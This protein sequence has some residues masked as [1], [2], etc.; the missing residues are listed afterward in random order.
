MQSR[1][2]RLILI[3]GTI[4]CVLLSFYF[5][6]LRDDLR[7]FPL[8][9]AYIHFVYAKNLA[10]GHGLSFNAGETSFGTSSPLWVFLLSRCVRA[11]FDLYSSAIMLSLCCYFIS[12]LMIYVTCREILTG[13][14]PLKTPASS[15]AQ[16]YSFAAALIYLLSG[17]MAWQAFSGMETTL[18]HAL[19]LM[20]LY[21][22]IKTGYGFTTALLSGVLLLCRINGLS[23]VLPLAAVDV[24]QGRRLSPF[25]ILTLLVPLPYY[26]YAKII[27]G[28]FFPVTAQGKL[29]TYVRADTHLVDI[30]SFLVSIIK[31]LFLY[32]PAF[33]LLIILCVL[34]PGAIALPLILSPQGRRNDYTNTSSPLIWRDWFKVRG[35]CRGHRG[36]GASLLFLWTL[37]DI[38][39]HCLFFPSLNNHLRYLSIIFLTLPLS[40][41]LLLFRMQEA[42]S[43]LKKMLAYLLLCLLPLMCLLRQPFWI[44]TY[45]NN[46]LHMKQVYSNCAEWI[47]NNTTAAPIA[48][49]DIGVLKHVTDR[50]VLDL[51][52]VTT[53]A[54]HPFLLQHNAGTYLREKG[55]QLIVYSRFPDC[56]VWSG[57]YRS[58]YDRSGLL[59]ETLLKSFSTDYYP[60]PSITHSFQ[61]DVVMID[62][63][64]PATPEGLKEKFYAGNDQWEHAVGKWVGEGL[65]L[66]GFSLEKDSLSVTWKMAQSLSIAY[67]WKCNEKL[68]NLPFIHTW[69]INAKTG[70]VIIHT[71]HIPT[72]NLLD[73]SMW[74]P[75]EVIKEHHVLW[76][77]DTAPAGTYEIWVSPADTLQMENREG[78][79][80][81]KETLFEIAGIP[82]RNFPVSKKPAQG[83]MIGTFVVQPSVLKLLY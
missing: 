50:T 40:G 7:V 31:Y 24:T 46:V 28:T 21:A 66:A 26:L 51:G 82:V 13:T 11:G 64:L 59:Q 3:P 27:S 62:R 78:S 53:G 29:L 19:C 55:A 41:G 77:P 2:V 38:T 36:S 9:D 1:L 33:F 49:F 71:V 52:G 12:A 43:L 16:L 18:Y 10:G 57:I 73:S 80:T 22:F 6:Y 8:D 20:C 5:L 74:N 72:H 75:G 35:I 47:K 70:E 79:S 81:L 17:N 58:E 42:G 56:D 34:I 67:F 39:V 54:V 45:H 63:W 4:F 61:L 83:L 37:T 69:F 32:E 15:S 44:N 30:L 68:E 65:E 48:A 14:L 25:A 76:V 60:A 23:L